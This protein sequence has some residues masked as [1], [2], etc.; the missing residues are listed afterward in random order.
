MPSSLVWDFL[1]VPDICCLMHASSQC[2]P[3]STHYISIQCEH[4]RNICHQSKASTSRL[5]SPQSALKSAS[6]TV[7]PPVENQ[8][9]HCSSDCRQKNATT[10]PFYHHGR[11]RLLHKH[12]RLLSVFS[13]RVISRLI[14]ESSSSHLSPNRPPHFSL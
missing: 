13:P 8:Q 11:H 7:L 4:A 14:Y 9:W 3:L 6:L 10:P 12:A 5:H 1:L 2:S